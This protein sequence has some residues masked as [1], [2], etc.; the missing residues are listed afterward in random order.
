MNCLWWTYPIRIYVMR[1]DT[2]YDAT[3]IVWINEIFVLF[4]IYCLAHEVFWYHSLNWFRNKTPIKVRL[5][6]YEIIIN[7]S[8]Y[9]IEWLLTIA[10]YISW[11]CDW[12]WIST[13]LIC[14]C[15]NDMIEAPIWAYYSLP[16]LWCFS[17]KIARLSLITFSF[18]LHKINPC[19]FLG[20]TIISGI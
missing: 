12:S 8:F 18:K 16:T 13:L 6:F 19:L 10:C 7:V 17:H 3:W 14:V 2:I 9:K 20:S 5:T 1:M 4:V 11:N 15:D